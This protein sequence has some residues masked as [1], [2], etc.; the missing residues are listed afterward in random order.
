MKRTNVNP[1]RRRKTASLR[2]KLLL[3]RQQIVEELRGGLAASQD[4]GR[5]GR[6]DTGDEAARSLDRETVLA[7]AQLGSSEIEQID[8]ALARLDSAAYGRCEICGEKISAR[9]LQV[10]PFAKLCVKCKQHEEVMSGREDDESLASWSRVQDERSGGVDVGR[11]VLE[12]L[13][14]EG[15]D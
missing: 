7:L 14:H 12:L 6:G 3:R 8:E 5:Y 15:R 2:S 4:N 11:D 10:M 9:R 1:G 13:H